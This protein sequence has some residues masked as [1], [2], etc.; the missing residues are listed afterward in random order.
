MSRLKLQV[1][2][3]CKMHRHVD[4]VLGGKF[5]SKDKF[6]GAASERFGFCSVIFGWDMHDSV[7]TWELAILNKD[8]GYRDLMAS[9]NLLTFLGKITCPFSPC[10]IL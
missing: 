2:Y 3:D 5:V 10:V 1:G 9:I 8:N 7:Y 6:L 4:D